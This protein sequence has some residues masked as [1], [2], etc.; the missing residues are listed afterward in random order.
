MN[1]VNTLSNTSTSPS[2][3]IDAAQLAALR[4]AVRRATSTAPEIAE[5]LMNEIDRADVI[6]TDQVPDSVVTLGRWVTY[7][8]VDSGS[9]RTIQLVLPNEAD[10]KHQKF[11][12]VSPIGAALIGLKVG[13]VM[14]WNVQDGEQ[15]RLTVLKTW[16]TR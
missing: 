1:T 5:Q 8:D 6:P 14:P 10:P 12:I 13:Q 15:R 3:I 7:Q 4:G 16:A 11:S 9:M 2:L